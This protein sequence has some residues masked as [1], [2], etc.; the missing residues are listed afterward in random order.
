MRY[1]PFKV[2]PRTAYDKIERLKGVQPELVAVLITAAQRWSELNGGYVRFTEGLRTLER[3]KELYRKGL[4]WTLDSK[5]LTGEAVDVALFP[6]GAISWDFPYY[7]DF[8]EQ[9]SDV[10]LETGIQVAWGG[11]WKSRDGVHF[12]IVG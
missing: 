5:H 4:S 3:Q 11:D 6:G 1:A 12:E 2:Y 8:A 7:A 10:C 9:V